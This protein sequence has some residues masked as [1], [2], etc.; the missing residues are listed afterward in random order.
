[1]DLVVTVPKDLWADW[2]DE[3]DCAGTPASG[4]EWGFF[5][6]GAQPPIRQG[7]RL[8]IV[9]HGMLRG[10]APVT[11]VAQVRPGVWG[12]GRQ[13]GAV[14]VTIEERI[15]GFRGWRERW[16]DRGKE[17]PFPDWKTAGV[18]TGKA[19]RGDQQQLSF[20]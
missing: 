12:I 4:E 7:E 16:W 9:A 8:Y 6:S 19:G 2:L 3:G 11:R 15:V 17:K 5:V 20:I 14:A 1:M 13:G 18:E 10:Y